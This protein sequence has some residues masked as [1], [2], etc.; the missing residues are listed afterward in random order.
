M[1]WLQTRISVSSLKRRLF[2]CTDYADQNGIAISDESIGIIMELIGCG[3]SD[4]TAW[5]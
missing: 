1:N 5:N 4:V 2:K 3:V